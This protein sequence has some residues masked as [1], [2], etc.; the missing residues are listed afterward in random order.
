MRIMKRWLTTMLTIS[1]ALSDCGSISVLA[2]ENNAEAE[3]SISENNTAFDETPDDSDSHSDD[4][5]DISDTDI[6]IDDEALELPALHIGQIKKDEGLP[7][8]DDTDFAYD[9]PVSFEMSD[10]I[11]LFVNYNLNAILEEENGALVWSILRGEKEMTPGSTS[12]VD[13]EDDWTDFDAVSSSPY[14][15]LTE[16]KDKESDYYQTVELALKDTAEPDAYDYYIRAAYYP[17]NE[18]I[19]NGTFYAAATIPFLPVNNTDIEQVPEDAADAE[20]L[21]ADP[22]QDETSVSE[23]TTA[24]EEVLHD[25]TNAEENDPKEASGSADTETLEDNSLLTEIVSLSENHTMD[26][27]SAPSE[28]DTTPEETEPVITSLTLDRT[29]RITL[30]PE[31]I[32]EIKAT[33]ATADSEEAQV[34]ILWESDDDTVATVDQN[35]F[36]TAVAEGYAKITASC[37]GV[38]ASVIVDV[39]LD[40]D[41]PENPDNGKLLDL[42][43]GIRVAGFQQVSDDLVYN[44]QKIT[45]NLRIYHGETL[46]K[47][48]T[49][50]TLSYKN[51]VNA[52]EWNTTKAPSVT[53]N[54]KGQYSGSVT[55]YYTIKPLDINKI[56]IY[57][58]TGS[59]SPGY[60]QA[61]NYS[62]KLNIPNPVL[63]FG[64]KKLTAKKDFVCNYTES[65]TDD[66]PALP[67]DYKNGDAY[68]TGKVY[69]YTVEGIGNFKGSFPMQLVVLSKEDKNKNFSSASIKLDQSKYLYQGKD[70]EKTDVKITELK[71]GKEILPDTLYDYEV[72]AYGLEGAYVKVYPSAAGVSAGYHGCKQVNLKL[73]GDRQI[74]EALLN[75]EYWQETILFSQKTVDKNG[76]MFQQGNRLLVFK[77][78]EE[79]EETLTEG[80][81]YTIK[82]SNAKKAGKVTVTFTGKGRYKG[83]LRQTYTITPNCDKKALKIIWGENV[84]QDTDGKYT[85]SYQKGGASPALTIRD[86]DYTILNSKT[87]YSVKLSG[88]KVPGEDPLIC[89]IIGKGNY[90]GYEETVEF[91]V[92]KA[93]IS[94]AALSVSDKP[95][96]EK[97]DKWKSTVTV[98]DVNGKKLAAKTDY[99]K[100]I[101]YTYENMESKPIPDKGTVVTVKVTGTGFYEG[102]L[103]LQDGYKIYDKAKDISK[104]QIV[105]DSQE[106]TG[107]EITLSPEK[108]IHVYANAADKKAGKEIENAASCYKIVEYKNNIKTGTAKVT[109]RG[110]GD[111]GG[112]KTYSFK[113][114]KKAYLKNSVKGI[115][116][117]P[118]TLTLSMM[119]LQDAN[120]KKGLLTATITSENAEKITNSTI[121]WTSS[122]NNIATVEELKEEDEDTTGDDRTT[123]AI[124]ADSTTDAT[125][126]TNTV[127]IKAKKEGSVTITAIS[128]DGNKKATCKVTITNQPVFTE[129]GQT[130]KKDEGATYQLHLQYAQTDDNAGTTAPV[131]WESSNPDAV[132]VDDTGLLTM[133]KAGVA[134]ITV[135]VSKYN[136]TGQCYAIAVDPNEEKPEG[137]VLT[138]EQEPGTTDDTPYINQKL[139][140]W[141]W[142]PS[143]YDCMYIPAGVYHIDAVSG[144]TDALGN[145]NFGGIVLTSNQ[146]L[147]MSPSAL[148]IAI[149]N[150]SKNY[151]VIYVFEQRDNV[152]IS[153]GQIIGDRREHKGSGGEQ[154]HGIKIEGSTNV[155]IENIEISYCWGDGISLGHY[156]K[157]NDKIPSNGITIE[158]CNLHHNRRNN[159]S[160]T[161]VSNVR[162]DHCQFNY[163][164]GTAPQYGIDIEPN[165]NGYT[166]EDIT[167]SNST[168]KGNAK[169]TIQIL[170]QKGANVKDV[171]ITG[172]KGNQKPLIAWGYGGGGTVS[173]VKDDASNNWNWN[174]NE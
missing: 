172:C 115:T 6:R 173:D 70:L 120:S 78:E 134:I 50:Y 91:V 12:L 154:G 87:D 98:T 152:T 160:I 143:E 153:G 65:G 139:R 142:N 89:T 107:E 161:D 121:I 29:T 31:E 30:E 55:L 106:Y 123:N 144:H 146:K 80:T 46:L 162:V 63:T 76:G 124:T 130:I 151:Q 73:E 41:N 141:E 42:S 95:Y 45:Q 149:P 16:N 167:I 81:D 96:D 71:I 118:N 138:Y 66:L 10:H 171:K 136:F 147:I 170:G 85:V 92:T 99:D 88:N 108:D 103:T 128:Q 116:L 44:G 23:N 164:S 21:P 22:I 9:L 148:L 74:K 129:D 60:E 69:Y 101:T 158:N 51:N 19:K 157:G 26:D 112:T 119:E 14:F 168:F 131:K 37:Y 53:I 86:Q 126:A 17:E 105:I 15:T 159:L 34:T 54:L 20:E 67:A 40:K 57:S 140:N 79:K 163:A 137:K 39:V 56:D 35:G 62:K 127:R 174:G 122:N 77:T 133:N 82:Y 75:E 8:P 7:D 102:E 97:P 36:I 117:N 90:K 11:V 13:E 165:I 114:L 58:T 72:C 132:S 52:A 94:K 18:S 1:I 110:D 33:A 27:S 24:D 135:T 25:E 3:S 59:K 48:K 145:Y 93:D 156:D 38:S 43:R 155:T 111:Y 68:E 125:T 169:G 150:S 61:V 109:L 49:D 84:T 5:V 4:D 104:L 166:C 100:D 64:K 113:I 32:I 2:A 47:E 28:D 83:S